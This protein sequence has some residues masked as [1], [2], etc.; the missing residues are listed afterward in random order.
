MAALSDRLSAN[1]RFSFRSQAFDADKFDVVNMEGYESI[2]QPFRFTLTLVSDDA[3]ID[4]DAMLGNPASFTIFAPGSTLE[5]PYHGVLAEFEQLHRANNHVFYRAVLVPR[6]WRLSLYQISEVYLNEQKVPDILEGILKS[7]KFSAADYQF[8]NAGTYR[9]RSYVC[10]YQES[11]LDFLSRWMEKEGMYYWFDHASSD[12]LIIAD[13]KSKHANTAVAVNYHPAHE[14]DTGV[15]ADSVQEFFCRQKP[16]PKQV[17]LQDFN[18]RKA[19]TPLKVTEP[20]S[21]KGVGDVMLYGENFRDEDEGKRYAKLRAQE[22]LARGKI[23]LGESTAVGLRSG[24]FMQLA[25]H[26]RESFNGK[27][28]VTELHHRGS[29]AGALLSGMQTPFNDNS[30]GDTSYYNSFQAIQDAVQFRA[31][32]VTSKPRVAG[33]MTAT[34]DSEGSGEYA[35]LDEYGQYKVQLPFDQT[36]KNAGKGSARIRMATPYSGGNHGM[37]LP[38]HKNAEVLLSFTDGDPDQPVIMAAVPNTENPSIVTSANKTE[39]RIT[40]AGGNQLYMDDTKGKEVIWMRSPFGNT[41]MGIGNNG[42]AAPAPTGLWVS[43]GGSSDSLTVGSTNS[44]FA[45]TKNSIS[46]SFDTSVTAAITH[47]AAIGTSIN[48]TLGSDVTWKAGRSITLDDSETVSLKT[49]AKTQANN[50][51]LISGGQRTALKALVEPLKNTVKAIVGFNIAAN[52]AVAAAAAYFIG[53]EADNK[54]VAPKQ[55]GK[56][57]PW[58][59]QGYGVAA[60]QAG[61]ATISTLPSHLVVRAAASAIADA[62]KADASYASNIKVND[63]GIDMTVD[64]LVPIQKSKVFIQ[65]NCVTIQSQ[66]MVPLGQSKIEVKPDNITLTGNGTGPL[67]GALSL[68]ATNADLE[69]KNPVGTVN[70]KHP[71]GGSVLIDATKVAAKSG[72]AE[73]SLELAQGATMSYATNNFLVTATEV[74][75]SCAMTSLLKLE[76][77]G[78]TLSYPGAVLTVGPTGARVNGALIQL[79]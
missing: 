39:S 44:A 55:D 23:F 34:I 11:H 10:Q 9:A 22:I 17:I 59:P 32:R 65:N 21:D 45:G 38:L 37:H 36:D 48:W 3:D 73:L 75:A 53:R 24:Y 78:A 58:A 68:S 6:L 14:L 47:K 51:V 49:D 26:Y 13:D 18:H 79:G 42:A 41:S 74:S 25:R 7:A 62:L 40:T 8:M 50:E 70:L 19:G 60:A 72:P 66:A 28:L 43:T 2:S 27:Y 64:S 15:A 52:V 71:V 57:K 1:R 4:F 35:D 76:A 61:L 16:L 29:Q 69:T 56:L 20:V 5:T 54:D 33:T 30:S 63:A 67:T 12:K 46:V 77:T 31:E